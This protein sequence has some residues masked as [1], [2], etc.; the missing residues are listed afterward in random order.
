MTT[1]KDLN[2]YTLGMLQ[3]KWDMD[4]EEIIEILG[5]YE[6]PLLSQVTAPIEGTISGLELMIL[7]PFVK[8]CEKVHGI[9]ANKLK[10][11]KM[12]LEKTH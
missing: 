11:K 5:T 1:F 8:Y 12:P 2:H 7:V 9:E 4:L 10:P 3:D 6:I